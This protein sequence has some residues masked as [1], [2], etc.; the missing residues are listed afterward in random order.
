MHGMA[1]KILRTLRTC[2]LMMKRLYSR[3]ARML[4]W[5]HW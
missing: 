3:K 1:E 2:F 4:R 5:V